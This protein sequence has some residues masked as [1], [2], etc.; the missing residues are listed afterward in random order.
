MC[1][2]V[3]VHGCVFNTEGTVTSPSGR[4]QDGRSPSIWFINGSLT[5]LI[6]D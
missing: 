3:R 4:S 2:G 5:D 1:G 6:A